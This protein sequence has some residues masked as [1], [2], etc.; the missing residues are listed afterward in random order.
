MVPWL[1]Q[2]ARAATLNSTSRTNPNLP[3]NQKKLCEKYNKLNTK[4]PSGLVRV[5]RGRFS[6]FQPSQK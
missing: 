1:A 6:V 5:S 3:I 2:T 4:R